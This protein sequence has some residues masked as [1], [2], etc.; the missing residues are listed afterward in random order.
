VGGTSALDRRPM[1]EKQTKG[2]ARKVVLLADR[3]GPTVTLG[4]GFPERWEKIKKTIPDELSPE[5]D[6]KL[7]DGILRSCNMFLGANRLRDIGVATAAAI[8]KPAGKQPA[9]L[10]SFANHLLAAS[11][12]WS[13]IRGLHDDHLGP[14]SDHLGIRSEFGSYLEALAH[15]AQRRL[16]SLRPIVATKPIP[17]RNIL[18]RNIANCCRAAGLN[19]IRHGRAYEEDAA[20]TWF[21]KLIAAVNDQILGL[22]GWGT[23]DADKRALFADVAKAMRGRAK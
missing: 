21:Q 3:G 19:P 1:T 9:P 7:R 6:A 17:A 2:K 12:T 22:Q 8:R 18:V 14:L 15:D 20:P 11:A 16:K 23:A 5:K 10:E 13:A 4:V